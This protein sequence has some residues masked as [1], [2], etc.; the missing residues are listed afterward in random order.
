MFRIIGFILLLIFNGSVFADTYPAILITKSAFCTSLNSG[1]NI[2]KYR[3]DSG[4]GFYCGVYDSSNNYTGYQNFYN[5]SVLNT[6]PGGG[7][8]SGS[9]CIN[10][11]A[12]GTGQVRSLTTGLCGAP[13]ELPDCVYPQNP[14]NASCKYH[15]NVAAINCL[16]GSVVYPP[17]VCPSQAPKW[18]DYFSNPL[19]PMCSP[20]ATDHSNCT[21]LLFQRMS[22][23]ASSH[24]IQYGMAALLIGVGG[25]KSLMPD[26]SG[27]TADFPVLFRNTVGESTDVMVKADVNDTAFGQAVT[28]LVKNNPN[29]PYVAG[30]PSVLSSLDDPSLPSI[31]RDPGTGGLKYSDS[32]VDLSANQVSEIV[33]ASNAT[34]PVPL[35]KVEPYLQPEFI[36]WLA[37]AD[38]ALKFDLNTLSQPSYFPLAT[39]SPRPVAVANDYVIRSASPLSVPEYGQT[40]P[41]V[42]SFPSEDLVRALNPIQYFTID[43][44]STY[45]PPS[46]GSAPPNSPG[47]NLTPATNTNPA[48]TDALTS[49]LTVPDPNTTVDPAIPDLPPTPPTIYPDT[50]KFFDFLQTVNPFNFKAQDFL[51]ALPE[52]T[53]SYE[54]HEVIHVP[55][56][57]DKNFDFA[58]CVP[59]QPL[60]DVL[61]W[62]FGVLTLWCCFVVVFR[63][64]L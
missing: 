42:Y 28:D 25:L 3:Y 2:W 17:A 55:F 45:T 24:A 49:Q 51:P 26:L 19:K 7:T 39:V 60:R 21:P 29:D 50:W 14:V 8:V 13:P 54:I 62:A 41:V 40:G 20:L 56:L 31:I 58:P 44:P 48:G 37:A 5:N 47:T 4:T 11:P 12:C 34:F 22:D 15:A 53:C 43:S 33:K 38:T 36:P 63:S 64:E 30:L 23:W 61:A 1:S 46:V 10:A 9:N 27:L 35:A 18:Q 16:N 6:C 52:S 32:S 59:L 57:G